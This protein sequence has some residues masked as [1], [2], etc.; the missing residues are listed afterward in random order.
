[1]PL[2]LKYFDRVVFSTV[3]FS[4]ATH[5]FK[6]HFVGL[7]IWFRKLRRS[8][9]TTF[10]YGLFVGEVRCCSQRECRS[11]FEVCSCDNT[12]VRNRVLAALGP[13]LRCG[14]L[15]W[16]LLGMSGLDLKSS[17]QMSTGRAVK[18]YVGS[19]G[20]S[21]LSGQGIRTLADLLTGQRS[22]VGTFGLVVQILHGLQWNAEILFCFTAC[23]E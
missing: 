6:H 4:V 3:C 23:V 7:D 9:V 2:R 14:T 20:C 18:A 5:H 12:I 16:T 10:E 11:K 1:M 17:H 19:W 8:I 21:S 15:G 13:V 22:R